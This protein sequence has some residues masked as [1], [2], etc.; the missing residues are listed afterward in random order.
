MSTPRTA[1]ARDD[2]GD[3][4]EPAGFF[5]LRAPLLPISE[6]VAWGEGLSAPRA[7]DPVELARALAS[8]RLVLRQRLAALVGRPEIREALFLASPSLFQSLSTWLAAPE[9]EAGR[10]TERALVRYFARMTGRATPFGLFAGCSVGRIGPQTR[11]VVGGLEACRRHTRLDADYLFALAEALGRDPA[12]RA[13]LVYRPNSSAYHLGGRLHYV[14]ERIEGE[15]RHHQIVALEATE[16][17]DTVLAAAKDGARLG[18]LAG[19]LVGQDVTHEEALAF[20]N[21]LVDRNVLVNE[22]AP[23]ATGPEPIHGLITQLS[24]SPVTAPVG[25]RLA[26][27]RSAMAA[28]DASPLGADPERYRA[29]ARQLAPLPVEADLGRLFQVDLLRAGPE[30]CLGQAV[31]A[32]IV[33]AFSLMRALSTQAE[34]VPLV[35]FRQAFVERYGEREVPLVLALDDELGI[36]FTPEAAVTD[37]SP[38]LAGLPIERAPDGPPMVRW[39]GRETVLLRKLGEALSAGATEIA[40]SSDELGQLS[41]AERLP[42]PDSTSALVTLWARSPEALAAGDFLVHVGAFMAPGAR[43]LGRFCHA[44]E[45][46][47]GRVEA[48]VRAEEARR[49]EAIFAEV[50]HLPEGRLGNVIFRPV[51]RGHEIPYL[52]RSGAAADRQIPVSDLLVSVREGRVLLR[53]GRLGREVVPCLTNAHNHATARNLDMYRFLTFLQ[54]QGVE[55]PSFSWGALDGAG[56]LPRVRVG[57]VVLSLARWTLGPEVVKSLGEGGASDRYRRVQALRCTLNLPRWVA[58]SEDDHVLPIDLDNALCVESLAQAIKRRPKVTLTELPGAGGPCV[59]GPQG[60]FVHQLVVP[61]LARRPAQRRS[62]VAGPASPASPAPDA[63]ARPRLPR[64]LLPGSD[65]LFVK[66]YTGPATADRL[67]REIVAPALSD[68]LASGAAQSWFFVRYADPDFHLRV[69]LHGHPARL[70][71]EVLPA[72]AAAAQRCQHGEL[73]WRMQIDTYEREVERYGGDEGMLLSER[74]FFADS[75]AVLELI[76]VL[77]GEEGADDRWRLALRGMDLLLDDLGFGLAQ[78]RELVRE[79]GASFAREFQL[80]PGVQRQLGARFRRERAALRALLEPVAEPGPMGTP[81]PV[82]EPALAVLRR[83]SRRVRPVAETLRTWAVADRL[84]R[85]LASL[86]ASYLHM[87]ANRVLRSSPREHELVLYDFLERLYDG[88]L[89]QREPATP[90]APRRRPCVAAACAHPRHDAAE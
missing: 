51:L 67:L 39:A 75:E 47:A 72:L 49:P 37:P 60:Q 30:A 63:P 52:A 13:G 87:H 41:R 7:T 81:G 29:I 84:T 69:R 82:P 45:E 65:W 3:A 54:L 42:P 31:L 44:D 78:K 83:R 66:L 89:A 77:D 20:V 38:L 88:Q 32:E 79:A 2:G 22:L 59:S 35:R 43:L 64:V 14:A 34:P 21:E 33:Q 40:L 57:R 71:A 10:R 12:V 25:E 80:A 74:I 85:P 19:A 1:R 48:L 36:G 5:V 73:L 11:L 16:C 55:R 76:S 68:A 26:E 56:F 6:L 46:L 4:I 70:N 9:S 24:S 86:A 17:L 58:F 50:A 27:A 8:D 62:A 53:S 23:A 15:A 61:F 90:G 18:A 28:L